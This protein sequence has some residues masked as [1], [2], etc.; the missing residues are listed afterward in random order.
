MVAR[1]DPRDIHTKKPW[2]CYWRHPS[3]LIATAVLASA[4]PVSPPPSGRMMPLPSPAAAAASPRHGHTG[5]VDMPSVAEW[6]VHGERVPCAG[7]PSGCGGRQTLDADRLWH[8]VGPAACPDHRRMQCPDHRRMQC[9]PA[10]TTWTQAPA[11]P[12]SP[13]TPW[14]CAC[15]ASSCPAS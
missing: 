8:T 11:T 10:S 7:R 12:Q 9:P 15:P 3:P 1:R 4:Q 13:A 5:C 14:W 2:R 6:H